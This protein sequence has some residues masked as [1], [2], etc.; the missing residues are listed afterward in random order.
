M[1]SAKR[2]YTNRAKG[3]DATLAPFT[4]KTAAQKAADFAA[5]VAKHST[6]KMR[7]KSAKIRAMKKA[8]AVANAAASIYKLFSQASNQ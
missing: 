2:R 4:V 5:L 8:T 7:P 1:K 3:I 6:P